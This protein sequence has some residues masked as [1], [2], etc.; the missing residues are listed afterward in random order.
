ML[1]GII[2]VL[3]HVA[4]GLVDGW[5]FNEDTGFI[6][7][8]GHDQ[9]SIILYTV[10]GGVNWSEVYHSTRTERDIVWKLFFPSRR[11]GYASLQ[12]FNDG[13]ERYFLKTTDGGTTWTERPFIANYTEQGIGFLNDSVGWIGGDGELANYITI[14]GGNTW[15]VDSTFG[16]LTP[17]Y[18]DY[19][20]DYNPGFAINRFRRFSDTLMYASGKTVYKLNTS[21]T[22]IAEVQSPLKEMYNYPNPFNKQTTFR[23]FLQETAEKVTLEIKDIEGKTVRVVDLGRQFAG[24][25]EIPCNMELST[26]VYYYT[27]FAGSYKKNKENDSYSIG[28]QQ[29]KNK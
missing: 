17:P 3:S 1:L 5:F 4:Q 29:T 7:G 28:C 8:R 2:R 22:G 16:I 21:T 10:D 18:H 9:K 6:S 11:I 12:S 27:V 20:G 13:P 26:G 14:D 23:Y 25:H 19:S 15:N 24:K